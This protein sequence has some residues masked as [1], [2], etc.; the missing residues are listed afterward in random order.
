MEKTKPYIPIDCSFYDELE[1]IALRGSEAEIIYLAE[2]N[3]VRK[4]GIIRS[5]ES[6]AGAE[7][8]ILTDGTEIR[9][10]NLLSINGKVLSTD[11]SC[12]TK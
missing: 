2:N 8:M 11:S 7:Y 4:H 6:K 1:L 9:L 3:P 10:D 5:L 12:D